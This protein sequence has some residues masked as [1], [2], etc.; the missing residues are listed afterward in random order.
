M[1]A[2][3]ERYKQDITVRVIKIKLWKSCIMQ[4]FMLG[5]SQKPRCVT[6]KTEA[7]PDHF[8][9]YVDTNDLDS[10]RSPDLIAKSIVD[11]VSS[12]IKSHKHDVTIS[13]ITQNGRFISKLSKV[14]TCLTEFCFEK[15]F[16]IYHSNA[17][18]SQHLNGS[19]L[20]LNRNYTSILQNT[21]TKVL[22]NF[23][24]WQKDKMV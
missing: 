4:M 5:V 17:L 6:W 3:R 11:A 14:N 16:L 19:K 15:I 7:N 12:L 9:L 24:S 2:A 22:S 1:K 21:F 23:F 10:D 20:N 13:N 18:K 8:V